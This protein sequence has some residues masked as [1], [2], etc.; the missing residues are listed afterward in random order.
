MEPC[1]ENLSRSDTIEGPVDGF[2]SDEFLAGVAKH[3]KRSA[4]LVPCLKLGLSR[5]HDHDWRGIRMRIRAPISVQDIPSMFFK[6]VCRVRA[7]NSRL[8]IFRSVSNSI[9][10]VQ[11]AIRAI[12][13]RPN[14]SHRLPLE[15]Y[16]Q[17]MR[18]SMD[19]EAIGRVALM[20]R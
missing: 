9:L 6:A 18:L 20:M 3:R 4:V 14:V 8:L 10:E 7:Q 16:A 17:A 1:V 11:M 2:D 5:A 15:E 19:R 12:K 13:M